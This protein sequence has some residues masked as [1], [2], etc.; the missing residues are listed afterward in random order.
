MRGPAHS[1]NS[2]SSA[3]SCTGSS[4]LRCEPILRRHVNRIF[5]GMRID[6]KDQGKQ[7]LRGTI[8]NSIRKI[9]NSNY[10]AVSVDQQDDWIMRPAMGRQGA[11]A[12]GI[13]PNGT[14]WFFNG[15]TGFVFYDA[16]RRELVDRLRTPS[17][18]ASTTHKHPALDIVRLSKLK[19]AGSPVSAL[20]PAIDRSARHRCRTPG[21]HSLRARTADRQLSD[22]DLSLIRVGRFCS[23]IL[24][25][26]ATGTGLLRIDPQ[27]GNWEI[28]ACGGPLTCVACQLEPLRPLLVARR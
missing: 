2:K 17:P 9:A 28:S 7:A 13:S 25:D 16:A 4:R 19:P 8:V 18:A 5:S 14:A 22:A 3:L 24:H 11:A 1:K 15:E 27:T 26:D 6:G 21:N 23:A 20:S 12:A 10:F